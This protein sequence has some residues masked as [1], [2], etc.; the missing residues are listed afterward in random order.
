VRFSLTEG[1]PT[2]LLVHAYKDGA[3][4]LADLDEVLAEFQK[5]DEVRR[6]EVQDPETGE[7]SDWRTS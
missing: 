5:S 2:T 6:I 3:D 7:W 1:K 4:G